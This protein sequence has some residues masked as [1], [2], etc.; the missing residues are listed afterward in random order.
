MHLTAPMIQQWLQNTKLTIDTVDPVLESTAAHYVLGRLA[1]RYDVTGWTDNTNTPDL[2]QDC[3]S[4]LVAAVIYRRSYAEVIDDER[5]TY[6]MWL[7]SHAEQILCCLM[8]GTILLADPLTT[9]S[10]PLYF[11]TELTGSS[12]QYNAAGLPVGNAFDADIKFRMGTRW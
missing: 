5:A 10:Q 6:P 3:M 7:E 11:P 1:A 8:D 9:T 4:M 12:Q 2:V